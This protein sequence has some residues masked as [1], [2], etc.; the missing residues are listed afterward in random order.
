MKEEVI[1]RILVQESPKSELRLQRYGEKKLRDLSVISGKWLRVFLEISWDNWFLDLF[2]NEKSDGLGPQH[3]DRAELL[4]S[5]VDRGGVDK[6]AR[7]RLV[8]RGR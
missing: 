6:R 5:T 8:G 2:F 3:V 7:R 4:G 1:L